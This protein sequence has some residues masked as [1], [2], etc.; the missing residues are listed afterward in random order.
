MTEKILTRCQEC[1]GALVIVHVL[2]DSG[3]Q[4]VLTCDCCGLP[5]E[6]EGGDQ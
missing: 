3:W 2:D 6:P 5:H 4:D 1:G